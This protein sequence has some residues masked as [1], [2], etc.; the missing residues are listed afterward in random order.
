M[1]LVLLEGLGQMKNAVTSSGMEP[2]I[3]LLVP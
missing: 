1:A 2:A 3:F